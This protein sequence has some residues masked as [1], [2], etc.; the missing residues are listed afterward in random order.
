MV[1]QPRLAGSSADSN[2]WHHNLAEV[3]GGC[4]HGLSI[5]IISQC[6]Y[7]PQI[8]YILMEKKIHNTIQE[9]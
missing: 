8:Y 3:L 4:F 9:F 2:V 7:I 1:M 5:L 6:L